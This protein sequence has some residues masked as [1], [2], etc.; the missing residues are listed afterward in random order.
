MIYDNINIVYHSLSQSTQ[1]P[2]WLKIYRKPGSI[3]QGKA[4]HNS[5]KWLECVD[6]TLPAPSPLSIGA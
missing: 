3:I 1:A 5:R 4:S 6:V 2:S